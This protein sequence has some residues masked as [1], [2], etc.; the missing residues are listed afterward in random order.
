MHSSDELV[1]ISALGVLCV[2][3]LAAL[4]A[5]LVLPFFYKDSIHAGEKHMFIMKTESG[6]TTFTWPGIIFAGVLGVG[7]VGSLVG[8]IFLEKLTGKEKTVTA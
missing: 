6:R 3:F 4:I 2:A 1:G 7:S 5:V 8:A